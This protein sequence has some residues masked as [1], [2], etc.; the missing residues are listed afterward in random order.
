MYENRETKYNAKDYRRNDTYNRND[1]QR[2]CGTTRDYRRNSEVYSGIPKSA[3]EYKYVTEWEREVRYLESKGILPVYVGVK[4]DW[5]I[6]Q[7]KYRKTPELGK[8]LCEFW[9][10]ANNE[11]E[12]NR[13]TREF[14]MPARRPAVYPR[15]FSKIPAEN[16]SALDP[17]HDIC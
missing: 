9:T 11:R 8:A 2:P 13:M 14:D 12:Y 17:E 1:A 6:R 5:G 3:Y 4:R 15:E 16:A 10:Q 7:Y